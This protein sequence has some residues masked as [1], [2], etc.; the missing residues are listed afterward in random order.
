MEPGADN[1]QRGRKQH[2][3]SIRIGVEREK[4]FMLFIS[5]AVSL[6]SAARDGGTLQQTSEK[7]LFSSINHPG[8]K[9]L[10]CERDCTK[11]TKQISSLDGALN[12]DEGL[13][14][15]L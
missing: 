11:S 1:R 9:W 4:S 13:T 3:E 15:D 5:S 6:C 14:Q 2:D 10:V 7:C 12:P 8:T